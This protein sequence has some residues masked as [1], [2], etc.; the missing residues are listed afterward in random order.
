MKQ[1]NDV[2]ECINTLH[3]GASSKKIGRN[4]NLMN[5][6]PNHVKAQTGFANPR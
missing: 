3:K 5:K 2:R 4:Y 1:F 6:L